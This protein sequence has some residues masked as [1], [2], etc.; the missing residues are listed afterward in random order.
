MRSLTSRAVAAVL[1]TSCLAGCTTTISKY[2]PWPK[3]GP[4]VA[5]ELARLPA[6]EYPASWDWIDRLAKIT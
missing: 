5:E 3:A 1:L 2:P 6:E 4:A